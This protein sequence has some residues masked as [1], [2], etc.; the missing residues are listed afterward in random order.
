MVILLILASNG[1]VIFNA[2]YGTPHHASESLNQLQ[3]VQ[4]HSNGHTQADLGPYGSRMRNDSLGSPYAGQEIRE[5]A[6]LTDRDIQSLLN[7]NGEAFG[8]LAK[9][10]E[11]NG[12]PGPRHVLDL[13]SNLGLN[14]SQKLK[15]E[16]LYENMSREAKTLGLELVSIEQDI[17]EV[18]SNGTVTEEKLKLM[19]ARSAELYGQ[20]RFIHLYANLDTLEILSVE[21]V[22]LYGKIRGYDIGNLSTLVQSEFLENNDNGP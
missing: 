4:N 22:Q 17:D 7:G 18:F 21:Q 3:T 8:G 5:I 10:A 14:E 9:S 12:Y 19:T 1:L 15:I 11:L 20:I 13:A 6:S 2:G 16:M